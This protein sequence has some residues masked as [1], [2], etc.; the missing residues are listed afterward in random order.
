[1]RS[2]RLTFP[3]SKTFAITPKNNNKNTM[4]MLNLAVSG[5]DHASV[6]LDQINLVPTPEATST[7]QPIAHSVLIDIFRDQL[8][9]AGLSVL[10]EHHTLARY[11]QRYFG[12]FQ[13]DMKREG[14]K[15]GTVVGLRNAHDKSFP[16]GICAGNAPFVCSNL[17]FHNEVVLG[18]KHTTHIMK[19]LPEIVSRAIGKLGDMWVKHEKRVEGYSNTMLSDE[20]AGHL[21][22]KGYRA[23]AIGKGMIVDV[24]DQ[25]EK[26]LHEEF[27]PRNLWSLHNAFTEVYKG[28]LVALPKRSEALHSIFDPFAGLTVDMSPIEIAV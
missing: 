1:M 12:L 9:T 28:N 3:R 18:R 2:N 16:A 15:S 24:L 26:P 4:K 14:A 27:A 17:C 13:I 10:S 22:L 21:I 5:A 20:Q 8:K 23:G 6:P 19:H 7:F 25:W 11:G